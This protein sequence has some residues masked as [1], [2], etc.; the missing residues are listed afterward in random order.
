[1]GSEQ[2]VIEP[3]RY[4]MVSEQSVCRNKRC[5]EATQVAK[6]ENIVAMLRLMP[7]HHML[8]PPRTPSKTF[9]ALSNV[10]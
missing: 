9:E 3:A 1:M 5:V 10:C 8:F 6:L 4:V 2:P 7:L